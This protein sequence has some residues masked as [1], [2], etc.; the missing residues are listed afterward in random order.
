TSIAPQPAWAE[1][2]VNANVLQTM[3]QNRKGAA[4]KY[5]KRM[6]G[7]TD[8]IGNINNVVP[9]NQ[10]NQLTSQLNNMLT[11]S[12][13]PLNMGQMFGGNLMKGITKMMQGIG[14]G[15]FGKGG[16]GG[17]TGLISE[18]EPMAD[19]V[20]KTAAN[21]QPKTTKILA[22]PIVAYATPI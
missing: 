22:N 15:G 8:Q 20:D 13:M 7:L 16:M 21:E 1:R 4:S 6:N 10:L 14:G 2:G 5:M 17:L 12:K 18:N 9:S 19:P 3:Q 11:L